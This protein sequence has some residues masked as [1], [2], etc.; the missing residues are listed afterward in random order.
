MVAEYATLPDGFEEANTT[1]EIQFH[2]NGRF[3]YGSNRGHDSLAIFQYDPASGRLTPRGNVPTGG[4]TPRNFRL[5]PDGKWLIAAN[6]NSNQ[7]AAFR[8]GED[9][10]PVATGHTVNIPKPVCIKFSNPATQP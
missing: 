2:P 8:V 9:G 1:A 10:I 4:K 7:L 3:V 6:Q 5:S